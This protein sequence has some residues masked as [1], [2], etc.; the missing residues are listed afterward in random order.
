M[1]KMFC[2][3]SGLML[4]RESWHQE[5][6]C[7]W[8]MMMRSSSFRWCQDQCLV[9][10]PW[11]GAAQQQSVDQAAPPETRTSAWEDW[12]E[13]PA[14]G[15]SSS[16]LCSSP[17]EPP[18]LP[19]LTPSS[20]SVLHDIFWM[21]RCSSLACDDTWE[22]RP[23]HQWVWWSRCGKMCRT[24]SQRWWTPS[25]SSAAWELSSWENHPQDDLA[26]W[27]DQDLKLNFKKY[28]IE[29]T[30]ENVGE[31]HHHLRWA[32]LVSM[33]RMLRLGEQDQAFSS[34]ISAA[35]ADQ[36]CHC[37]QC[38]Q[39]PTSWCCSSQRISC[40]VMLELMLKMLVLVLVWC[41]WLW[42]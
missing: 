24:R 21:L 2:L 3:V 5:A 15:Q 13:S 9:V 30:L 10:V 18:V 36:G 17:G 8:I 38:H 23:R 40:L 7:C 27:T 11:R 19:R 31:K 42:C 16:A 34:L 20:S 26:S 28:L 32:S 35:E 39:W 33:L 25:S 6:W 14:S 4:T 37:D 29:F 1:C 41:S 12:H 22:R